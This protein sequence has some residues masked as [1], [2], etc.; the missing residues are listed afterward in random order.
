MEGETCPQGGRRL[1]TYGKVETHQCI[2]K[3][4]KLM[5]IRF[6]EL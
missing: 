6:E 5:S 1:T 4:G 3:V 2:Q